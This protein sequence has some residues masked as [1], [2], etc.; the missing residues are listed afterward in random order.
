[1]LLCFDLAMAI[2]P[3]ES[4]LD[5]QLKKHGIHRLIVRGLIAHTPVEATIR[6]AAEL[7]YDQSAML[8]DYHQFSRIG[9]IVEMALVWSQQ[10]ELGHIHRSRAASDVR[11]DL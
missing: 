10:P 6:Y 2:S 9:E 5:L 1:M 3:V 7:G 8:K 4:D 11:A